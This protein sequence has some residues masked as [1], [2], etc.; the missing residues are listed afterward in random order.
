MTTTRTAGIGIST[1]APEERA[2]T[3]DTFVTAFSADPFI[4]WMYPEPHQYLTHFGEFIELFGGEAFEAGT[5]YR[6][7]EFAGASLWLGPGVE[8]DE[9]AVVAQLQR[10][11]AEREQPALF[12]VLEQMEGYHPKE[13]VWY[14]P[15]IGVD[16]AR[17][18]QGYGSALLE[19]A[20]AKCDEEHLPAYLE[21][22]SERNRALYERHGFE[23]IGLIQAD[24]SPPLWPML[25][26]AH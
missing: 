4:R 6:S 1:A 11:V 16:P 10:S 15:I 2:R 26:P 18:G 23:V 13:P 5:A 24:D 25:R 3:I 7:D 17:Q 12:A 21:A 9:A 8:A 19:H 20:L 22:S 14:L